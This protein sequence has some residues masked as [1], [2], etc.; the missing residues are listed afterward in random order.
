MAFLSW[1]FVYPDEIILDWI[2]VALVL[3]VSYM[4]IEQK[5]LGMRRLTSPENFR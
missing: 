2:L 5:K 3:T 4:Y 1:R